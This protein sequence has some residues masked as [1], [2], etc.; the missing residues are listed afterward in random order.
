MID[1]HT[2][3]LANIDDGPWNL[4]DSVKL[5]QLAVHSGI[6]TVIAT[7][8]YQYGGIINDREKV[9]NKVSHFQGLLDERGIPLEVLPGGEIMIN[10][11]HYDLL[12]KKDLPT[13]N[14]SGK[15]ILIEL[16]MDL[17]PANLDEAIFN[18]RVRGLTPIIA[19][20]ERNREVIKDP[21]L[22][23][24]LIELGALIQANA[25]SM[26]GKNGFR[27]MRTAEILL[28]QNMVHFLA[29]DTHSLATRVP[30]LNAA[31]SKVEKLLGS[32]VAQRLVEDNPRYVLE[33][34]TFGIEEPERYSKMFGLI[35]HT[36]KV[37]VNRFK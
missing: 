12:K 21:N 33:G 9:L 17:V 22:V 37:L 1:I 10:S 19:H 25:C 15:Y 5:A 32:R 23:L 6:T 2:H 24:K 26:V 4:N 3:I 18:L 11:Y 29:S 13:L 20:P 27:V 28:F 34:K 36:K 14:D 16:P 8:H 30:M 31:S 35:S 7:P